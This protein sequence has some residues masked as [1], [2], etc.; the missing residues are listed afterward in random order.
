MFASPNRDKTLMLPYH[1][2]ESDQCSVQR[3]RTERK[4]DKQ[5]C[6]LRLNKVEK[7]NKWMR[8]HKLQLKVFCFVYSLGSSNSTTVA[9]ATPHS[10][11]STHIS[12]CEE[13]GDKEACHQDME[14]EQEGG[15]DQEEEYY[16]A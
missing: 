11:A 14:V 4:L 10:S 3:K 6:S 7:E 8:K 16:D 5:R 1:R 2:Y 9:P 15:D 12:Y 13:N